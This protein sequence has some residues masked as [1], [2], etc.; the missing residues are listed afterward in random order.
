M[1]LSIFRNLRDNDYRNQGL[2]VVEGRIV[3]DKAL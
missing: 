1:D 3:A 2:I